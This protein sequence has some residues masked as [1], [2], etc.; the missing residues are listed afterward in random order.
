MDFVSKSEAYRESNKQTKKTV[1][2]EKKNE[3]I[4]FLDFLNDDLFEL[5]IETWNNIVLE[6]REV[7]RT[8]KLPVRTY[9][10]LTT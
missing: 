3:S 10:K 5:Q 2:G 9:V 6:T 1:G 4:L 7:T 8:R